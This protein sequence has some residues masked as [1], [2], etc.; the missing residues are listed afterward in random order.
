LAGVVVCAVSFGIA[1][2]KA[3]AQRAVEAAAKR[4]V[5]IKL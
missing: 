5:R 1:E 3:Y 4:R 2:L